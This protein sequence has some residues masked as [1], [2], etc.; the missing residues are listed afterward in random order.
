VGRSHGKESRHDSS[1]KNLRGV[2]DGGV[3]G[4]APNYGYDPATGLLLRTFTGAQPVNNILL[5]PR[6]ATRYRVT[7]HFHKEGTYYYSFPEVK[8]VATNW[9][10]YSGHMFRSGC[11]GGRL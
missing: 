10:T 1:V 8:R 4:T 2:L 9:H 6:R 7:A 3:A 5:P 11:S